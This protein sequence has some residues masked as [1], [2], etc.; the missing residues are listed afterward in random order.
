MTPLEDM[1]KFKTVVIDP[2]W[3]I[4]LGPVAPD[5]QWG[6]TAPVLPYKAM[7]L[8]DIGKLPIGA[9]LDDDSILFCWTTNRLLKDCFGI[10]DAWGIPY[11]FTFVWHKNDGM[12]T[13]NN[14][15]HT[16]EFAIVGRKGSP[17]WLTTKSFRTA[18]C[19]DRTSHSEKP[20]GFYD[21]L[22]PRNARPAPRHIRTVRR[23]AGF[24]SLG[25]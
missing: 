19:W 1:G 13:P 10:L 2:P 20:E 6:K 18:N 7:R 24:H 14:P 8:E 23:I 22:T 16:A 4:Q 5:K 15:R 3:D 25:Q 17:K 21:L 12:Q 9:T 11:W